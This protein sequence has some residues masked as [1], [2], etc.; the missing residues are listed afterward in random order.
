MGHRC[1][2]GTSLWECQVKVGFWKGGISQAYSSPIVRITLITE[3]SL[4]L[5]FQVKHFPHNM[6]FPYDNFVPISIGCMWRRT[7]DQSQWNIELSESWGKLWKSRTIGLAKCET[8]FA[9]LLQQREFVFSSH[10]GFTPMKIYNCVGF[11]EKFREK[12]TFIWL[13]I[14][15]QI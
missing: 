6:G 5:V 11:K 12:K 14:I 7:F 2:G 8:A 13:S 15:W 3:N 4:L 9:L 1:I 10:K